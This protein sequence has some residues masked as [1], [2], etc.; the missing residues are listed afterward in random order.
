MRGIRSRYGVFIAGIA[1][2]LAI[3]A[4]HGLVIS[5]SAGQPD[6]PATE[7]HLVEPAENAS[8]LWP[9]TSRTESVDGRT[10]ALN[11]I[12]YGD[13]DDIQDRFRRDAERDWEDE[14]FVDGETDD[15]IFPDEIRSLLWRDAHGADRFS[16]VESP[17][18]EG[19]WIAESYQLYDG[20]YLGER[21]HIRAYESPD[22]TEQWV[23]MQ[24][25]EE[26]FDYFRLK[27][28][29]TST[30][31]AQRHVEAEF[32]EDNATTVSQEYLANPRGSDSD[33][34]VTFIDLLAFLSVVGVLGSLTAV[35]K[36]L[37]P[38][39]G[40]LSRSL[41]GSL[42]PLARYRLHE[43]LL[44]AV[45]VGLYL[46]VRFVGI[47]LEEVVRT[48]NPQLFAGGLYLV[49]AI[50]LP[51]AVSIAAK[52]LKLK[53]AF[54]VT[55]IAFG[56]AVLLDFSLIGVLDIPRKIILHRILLALSLGLIAAG[57]ALHHQGERRVNTLFVYGSAGWVV[58]LVIAL[59]DLI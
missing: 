34:W 41:G 10:L 22:P 55:S 19:E 18:G 20:R 50:G 4:F 26:Y 5:D 33:G 44:V 21:Q 37:S 15:D 38:T 11:L 28:T 30:N 24:A 8:L 43:A 48:V 36:R 23:A 9:Y 59:L 40:Q 16:Y 35:R 14:P 6:P 53:D 13:H 3:V 56:A 45:V 42:S 12:V 46:G 29:V 47:G 27:H 17:D 32:L 2:V 39:T 49:L 51:V 52:Y 7:K 57:A 54:L 1:V 58:G 25:H 31:N